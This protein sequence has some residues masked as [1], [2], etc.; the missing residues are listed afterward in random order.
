MSICTDPDILRQVSRDT[1]LDEVQEM[2][3]VERMHEA[4]GMA[5]CPSVGI[6]AI[7]I[8]V[9]VRFAYHYVHADEK[10]KAGFRVE[11]EDPIILLNPKIIKARGI[12]PFQME[13]CLSVPGVRFNT[14]RFAH[15][16]YTAVEDE[17]IVT[18]TASG[19]EAVVIQHEVGHMDGGLL[20]DHIKKPAEPGRNEPCHCL[21]G[22]KFK[23][24]CAP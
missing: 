18:K 10:E 11:K 6:S 7:Q 19:F 21:S 14:W 15:I 23:K 24:C 22:L 3:L 12:A 2:N 17:K 8:G 16:V 13:G 9:P 20:I 5:W 4:E 1:T